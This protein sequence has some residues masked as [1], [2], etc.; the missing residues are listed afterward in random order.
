MELVGLR[1]NSFSVSLYSN[2]IIKKKKQFHFFIVV[3][4]R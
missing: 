3:T 4:S 2:Y 1:S